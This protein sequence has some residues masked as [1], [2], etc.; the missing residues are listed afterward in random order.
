MPS[1]TG[2]S[3]EFRASVDAKMKSDHAHRNANSET[4]MREFRLSG[5]TIEVK[6]VHAPAPSIL[7]ACMSSRGSPAMKAASRRTPKGTAIVESARMSP[8]TV[9]SRPMRT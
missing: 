5:R 6:A 8:Q 3:A 7:E 2:I 9:F 4:V 1:V